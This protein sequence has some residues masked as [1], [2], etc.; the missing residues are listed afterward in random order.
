MRLDVVHLAVLVRHPAGVDVLSP[1]E[2]AEQAR[3]GFGLDH[4]GVEVAGLGAFD[5]DE[6][7]DPVRFE[8]VA[9]LV[10]HLF[11]VAQACAVDDVLFSFHASILAL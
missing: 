10:G 6:V 5:A 3:E 2:L 11:D 8:V 9:K 1:A 7:R 4:G